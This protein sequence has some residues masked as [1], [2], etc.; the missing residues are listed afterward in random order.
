MQKLVLVVRFVLV[1]LVPVLAAEVLDDVLPV[2]VVVV[3]RLYEEA[4][5]VVDAIGEEELIVPVFVAFFTA[6]PPGAILAAADDDVV[7]IDAVD[8]DV[9]Q[10]EPALVVRTAPAP[11]VVVVLPR[12]VVAAV[13]SVRPSRMKQPAA[14]LL[15]PAPVFAD[16]DTAA[17]GAHARRTKIFVPFMIISLLDING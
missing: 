17:A 15:L 12:D 1:A 10:Q 13:L 11:A 5:V 3:L 4:A 8:V 16:D 7:V 6:A 14:R 2:V 9:L